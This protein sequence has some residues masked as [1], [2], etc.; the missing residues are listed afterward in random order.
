[1]RDNNGICFESKSKELGK[2]KFSDLQRNLHMNEGLLNKK[3]KN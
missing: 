2:N 1:M 3:V